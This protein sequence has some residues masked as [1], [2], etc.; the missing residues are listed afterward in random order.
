MLLPEEIREKLPPLY[1]NDGIGM[2]AIAQVKFFTPSS[3]WTWYA[4]EY[5]GTDRFFGLVI[6][7]EIELGYFSLSELEGVGGLVERDLYFKPK[8]L[9]EIKAFYVENGYAY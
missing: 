2:Q 7:F 3:D 4:T 8:S 9:E 1:T 5:D 6:G